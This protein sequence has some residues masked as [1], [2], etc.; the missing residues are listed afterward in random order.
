MASK[1][2]SRSP[3]TRGRNVVVAAPFT[4]RRGMSKT[5]LEADVLEDE[6]AV[7]AP[8]RLVAGQR[9]RPSGRQR[10][11]CPS[12]RR[13]RSARRGRAQLLW[14][15][16]PHPAR[17]TSSACTVARTRHRVRGELPHIGCSSA[18]RVHPELVE[19]RAQAR[20]DWRY[21]V[22]RGVSGS[23]SGS[24]DGERREHRDEDRDPD[25]RQQYGLLCREA[26]RA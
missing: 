15:C 1:T 11:A 20:G 4:S 17:Q 13:R 24:D 6:R 8:H 12:R 23:S 26:V 21:A 2:A 7:T 16:A 19:G 3:P 25:Q 18:C 22:G 9:E 10:D 14:T 5:E